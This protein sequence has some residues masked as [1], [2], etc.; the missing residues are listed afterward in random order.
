[1]QGIEYF[2]IIGLHASSGQHTRPAIHMVPPNDRS[3]GRN[4]I[5]HLYTKLK[6]SYKRLQK[7]LM[8]VKSKQQRG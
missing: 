2:G 8:Q 6:V 3:F 5:T 1:M 4:R 7:Q